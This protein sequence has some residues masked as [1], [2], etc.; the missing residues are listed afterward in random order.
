MGGGGGKRGLWSSCYCSSQKV[1]VDDVFSEA[2]EEVFVL[3]CFVLFCFV[4]FCFVLFCFLLFSFVFDFDFDFD[5]C[6]FSFIFQVRASYEESSF[7]KK[8][9]IQNDTRQQ[10][11]SL[12]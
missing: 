9:Q 3:F 1:N 5:F 2:M 4:L 6:F 10:A 11:H 8:F 7:K 12:V